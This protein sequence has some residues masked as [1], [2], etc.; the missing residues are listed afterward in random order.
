LPGLDTSEKINY[1]LGTKKI[2]NGETVFGYVTREHK[3]QK[4]YSYIKRC[5]KMF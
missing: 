3:M 1:L 5:T 4:N 2:K